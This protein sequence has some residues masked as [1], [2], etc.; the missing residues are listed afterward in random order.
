L[1]R[2]GSAK[3]AKVDKVY[4]DHN[5]TT[6]TDQRVIEAMLPYMREHWG[7][8]SSLHL[9]GRA[10][11]EGL[12]DSREKI[13]SYLNC[14]SDEIYFTSGGTE[15]DNL[16][17][18]GVAY[19]RREKGRHIITSKIE[20]QAVLESCQFLERDGFEV[21]YLPVDKY[22][23]V[24]PDELSKAIRKDTTLVSIMY[25]NNEVG[26]I[27]PVDELARICEE[28]GV[29][30][31]TDA[32]QAAGRIPVDLD[33]T[34]AALVSASAH[35]IYGPK[36]VG[37][38]FIRAGTHIE[39]WQTGGHHESGL[40]AGTVNVPGIVGYAKAMEIAVS[41]MDDIQNRVDALGEDFRVRIEKAVPDAQF[42]GHLD[43]RMKGTVNFCFRG[44]EG[45]AL[46]LNL[47]MKGIGVSSGSACTSGSTDPSHVLLAMGIPPE[48]AQSSVRFSFGRGN[49]PEDVDHAV[50][51][52]KEVVERLRSMSPFY[53][54]R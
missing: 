43:K 22:G 8:S 3:E 13:A 9:F 40:R 36:G 21:T 54:E 30:F 7:N 49:T 48:I 42:N 16:A 11:L 47:D 12:E 46:V 1:E 19:A 35:K 37:A 32:V 23:I 28:N 33:R 45:E 5:A 50:A 17:I 24:D 6:P 52:V 34:R 2:P 10:A 53:A 14:R 41:E 25:V 18:K 26:A 38:I 27:Q 4:L 31:H 20:H 15:S 39:T 44:A 51:A 29:Y